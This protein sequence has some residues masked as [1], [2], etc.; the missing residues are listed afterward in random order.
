MER[1]VGTKKIDSLDGQMLGFQLQEFNKPSKLGKSLHKMDFSLILLIHH[2]SQ[3]LF[4][5]STM[6]LM[7][8]I[9]T[10]FQLSNHG[11]LMKDI[12]AHYKDLTSS[13]LLKNMVRNKFLFGGEALILPHQS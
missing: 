13:R 3:E 7:N 5:H 11:G 10:I 6:Q 12:M 4:K 2:F 9:V 1:A 8:L